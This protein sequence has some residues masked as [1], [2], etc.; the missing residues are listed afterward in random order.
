M[1]SVTIFLITGN[2]S[3]TISNMVHPNQFKMCVIL[4]HPNTHNLNT[5]KNAIVAYQ[6]T[7][8]Q[9]GNTSLHCH[10][11]F[12]TFETKTSPT[13]QQSQTPFYLVSRHIGADY[14]TVDHRMNGQ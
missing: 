3:E 4:I 9:G 13:K 6:R 5:A 2:G 10:I 12:V 8:K 7:F 11:L 14:K 1:K